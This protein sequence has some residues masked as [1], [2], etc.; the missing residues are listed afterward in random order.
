[1]SAFETGATKCPG[2]VGKIDHSEGLGFI[3]EPW[4][5]LSC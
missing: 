5:R 3:S 1:M 2:E 4:N